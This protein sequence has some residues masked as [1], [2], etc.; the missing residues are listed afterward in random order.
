MRDGVILPPT[1]WGVTK[2]F[3]KQLYMLDS[4]QMK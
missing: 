1:A 3:T 2:E 4:K